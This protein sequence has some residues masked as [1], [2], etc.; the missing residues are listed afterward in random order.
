M[1]AKPNIQP[2]FFL[3]CVSCAKER[4]RFHSVPVHLCSKTLPSAGLQQNTI[5]LSW[6]WLCQA[7]QEEIYMKNYS[8]WHE[9]KQE[10]SGW[11]QAH[12]G[13][14][15]TRD[16][17][18]GDTWRSCGCSGLPWWDAPEPKQHMV[19]PW[20]STHILHVQ[21][22]GRLQEAHTDATLTGQTCTHLTTQK[23]QTHTA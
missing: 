20:A 9:H 7:S 11:L 4:S 8:W 19:P 3:Y 10:E 2:P 6:T 23:I 14:W 16:L 13:G 15:C 21:Q 17:M 5:Y 22:H 12:V 18:E 1:K